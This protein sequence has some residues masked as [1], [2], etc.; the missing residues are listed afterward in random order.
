MNED[1]VYVVAVG[2]HTT[3]NGKTMQPIKFKHEGSRK[4]HSTLTFDLDMYQPDSVV[5]W[6][7]VPSKDNTKQYDVLLPYMS[8]SAARR[9]TWLSPKPAKK[10]SIATFF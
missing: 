6:E 4:I 9:R 1:L 10:C 2:Q 8:A 5:G 7:S 3:I